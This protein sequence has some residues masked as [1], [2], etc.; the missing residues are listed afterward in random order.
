VGGASWLVPADSG[1]GPSSPAR[2]REVDRGA[3]H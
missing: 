1:M 3:G 2:G